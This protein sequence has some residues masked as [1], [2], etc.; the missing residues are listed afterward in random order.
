MTIHIQL[1]PQRYKLW[2]GC[3][4]VLVH[5]MSKGS[6]SGKSVT[7]VGAGAGRESRATDSHLILRPH[8][9]SGGYV[10]EAAVR[11]WPPVEPRLLHWTWPLWNVA[12]DLDSANLKPERPPRCKP[13]PAP[14]AIRGE[15]KPQ[16]TPKRFVRGFVAD[17]P[18]P[19]ARY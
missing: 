5:H 11:S 6:Q 2:L 13:D 19:R 15:S 8:R 1:L 7:D 3:S 9:E 16:W 12:D 18:Q 4:F 10:V 14:E 17:R